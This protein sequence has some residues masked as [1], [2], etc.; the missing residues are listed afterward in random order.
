MLHHQ[1]ATVILFTLG[2][3]VS[4]PVVASGQALFLDVGDPS[5]TR[6]GEINTMTLGAS[7]DR[8]ADYA[9][10]GIATSLVYNEV[11]GEFL[12]SNP[13]LIAPMAGPG[14]SA[15]VLAASSIDDIIAG[16]LNF[17]P[18]GIYA[19]PT[20]PIFFWAVDYTFEFDP[21][22][23]PAVLDLQT[24]TTRFDVYVSMDSATSESRLGDLR[25]VDQQL[26]I[27][28]TPASGSALFLGIAMATRR[29]R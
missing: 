8:S 15:G 2:T 14:T 13:R 10:A 27:F 4:C 19:D 22:G 6:P 18:A 23:G 12:F 28:P 16:Q 5:P 21:A 9:V 1:S 29:R 11:R 3:L 17:P 7:F 20:N 25:E 26:V 24:V